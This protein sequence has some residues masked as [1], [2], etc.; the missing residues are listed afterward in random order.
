MLQRNLGKGIFQ[1]LGRAEKEN[2]KMIQKQRSKREGRTVAN[3]QAPNP[4]S[5]APIQP[6]ITS[7]GGEST[8][9]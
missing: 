8:N 2:E 1:I 7:I 6:A 5:L 3:Q 9:G 4:S